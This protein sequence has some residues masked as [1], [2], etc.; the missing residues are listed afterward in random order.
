MPIFEYRSRMPVPVEALFAWHSRPGAL[1]RL[2][3]PWQRIEI[4]EQRGTIHDGDRVMLAIRAGP[5]RLRW[6]AVHEG[7]V[8]GQCFADRQVLGPFARWRHLHEFRTTGERESELCDRIEFALPLGAAGGL[9]EGSLRR[10]V[11][12]PLFAWRHERTRRDLRRHALFADRPRLR[13]AIAG[14]SG[15]VGRQLSAF[16]STGGHSVIPMVRNP[17][18][19]GGGA[20]VWQPDLGQIDAA[21]LEGLDAVIHL[22]GENIAEKPWTPQRKERLRLSRVGS[23]RL[24]A[25]TLAGLRRPPAV[26]ICASATGFYGDRGHEVLTEDSGPGLGFLPELCR[27]WEA[28]CEPARAAGIRVVCARLGIVLTPLGG[29]LARMLPPF[30]LGLGGRLG[31]G[32]QFMSWISLDDAVGALHHLLYSEGLSGAVNLVAPNPV[33]NR[34]FA[35]TLGRVLGRPTLAP[36]PAAAVRLLFGE[37]GERLL[38]EGQRVLPARLTGSGFVFEFPVL[39]DALRWELGR[40]EASRSAALL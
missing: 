7:Y 25:E 35:A 27:E 31:H 13:V 6:E 26:M 22:G 11:L 32:E 16:L 3:A 5:L 24:L 20:I 1:M 2:T 12:E 40:V 15:L 19:A 10:R 30:R 14:S 17:L 29:A 28:A 33:S 21:G 38:L 18:A 23:T 9:L 4:L 39:E 37:L 36:V 34:E 8:E